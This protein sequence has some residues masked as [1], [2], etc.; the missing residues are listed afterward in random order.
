MVPGPP[1]D[2]QKRL[3]WYK[4]ETKMTVCQVLQVRREQLMHQNIKFNFILN[5]EDDGEKILKLR[6]H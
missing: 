1:G 4:F 6:G 5:L 2:P 3:E